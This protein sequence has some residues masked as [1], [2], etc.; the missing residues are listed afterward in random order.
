MWGSAAD[1]VWLTGHDGAAHHD[2]K[3]WSVVEGPAGPLTAVQGHSRDDVWLAGASG[4]WHG[5]R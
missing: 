1:D 2:G 5:V 3:R 4:V